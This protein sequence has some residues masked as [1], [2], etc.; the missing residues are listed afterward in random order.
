MLV[1]EWFVSGAEVMSQ[2]NPC[3]VSNIHFYVFLEDTVG[4]VQ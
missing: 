2:L 3:G 1:G 4:K